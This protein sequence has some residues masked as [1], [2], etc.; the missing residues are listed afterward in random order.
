MVSNLQAFLEQRGLNES[1]MLEVNAN[2]RECIHARA[3][4]GA[5]DEGIMIGIHDSGECP[6][7]IKYPFPIERF[8]RA[9]D[10]LL[11]RKDND[12]K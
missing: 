12:A 6:E 3:W 4:I 7:L 5:S 11:E 2:V 8:W 9:M 1:T 10:S